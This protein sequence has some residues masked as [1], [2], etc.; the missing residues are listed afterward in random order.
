MSDSPQQTKSL[1]EQFEQQAA[2]KKAPA[3]FVLT[4]MDGFEVYIHIASPREWV[5]WWVWVYENYDR[6]AKTGKKD[7][8]DQYPEM[9]RRFCVDDKDKPLFQNTS[10][11]AALKDMT[12][13]G[14]AVAEFYSECKR[15]NFLYEDADEESGA[16]AS[17]FT[18]QAK[19]TP[20]EIPASAPSDGS[21]S[22]V[23]KPTGE[24]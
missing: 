21:Q 16:R 17:F 3:K 13:I 1:R 24:A 4:A 5:M 20:P 15:L 12:G 22:P 14:G 19:A 8:H 11:L 10:E 6:K 23:D 2:V 18:Q 9:F 7:V